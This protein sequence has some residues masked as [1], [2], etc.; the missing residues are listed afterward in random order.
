MDPTGR[1]EI[2]PPEREKVSPDEID[3]A[4]PVDLAVLAVRASNARCLLPGTQKEITLRSG[5]LWDVCPG[6]VV[7]VRARKV[8]TYFRHTYISGQVEEHRPELGAFGL[9][10]LGLEHQGLWEPEVHYWGE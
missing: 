1:T 3:V 2:R 5:D 8:W 10:P 7:K 6:D 9:M 4:K